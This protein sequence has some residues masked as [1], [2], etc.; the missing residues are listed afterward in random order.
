MPCVSVVETQER[1]AVDAFNMFA[2]TWQTLWH[3]IV[4]R[5]NVWQLTL[6][7][8]AVSAKRLACQAT[9]DVT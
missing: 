7:F 5:V 9:S 8:N 4:H 6:A 2:D 3:G 1:H